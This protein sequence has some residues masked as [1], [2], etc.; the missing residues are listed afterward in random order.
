MA[1]SL[2]SLTAAQIAAGVAAGELT[3]TAVAHA[4]LDAVGQ[5][6]ADVQAFLQVT[7]ELALKSAERIDA[8][9]AAGEPLPPLAGVPFAI[10]DNMNLTGTRTT[11]SLIHI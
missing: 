9:R 10:K 2:D 7:P 1:V 8:A 4:A 5:R 3:A 6:D 11:L